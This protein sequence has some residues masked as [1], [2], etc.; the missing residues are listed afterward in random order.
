M[1]PFSKKEL[2]RQF[3]IGGDQITAVPMMELIGEVKK[4]SLPVLGAQ[5]LFLPYKVVMKIFYREFL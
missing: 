4:A 5:A 1:Y 3:Y 2:V